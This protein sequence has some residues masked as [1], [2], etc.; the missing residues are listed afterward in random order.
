MKKKGP[1]VGS[2]HYERY[3]I[4]WVDMGSG[5]KRGKGGRRA[6]AAATGRRPSS[7]TGGATEFPLRMKNSD[8][9]YFLWVRRRTVISLKSIYI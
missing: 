8:E 4:H 3:I 7:R 1:V 2:P 5:R 9:F 6:L